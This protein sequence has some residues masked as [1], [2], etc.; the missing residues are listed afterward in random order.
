MADFIT[1]VA[2]TRPAI[3]ETLRDSF[4]VVNLTGCTVTFSAQ[5]NGLVFVDAA[6]ATVTDATNGVVTFTPTTSS[7]TEPGTYSCQWAVTFPSSGGTQK[8]PSGRWFTVEV[9]G[10]QASYTTP[11]RPGV[12]STAARPDASTA[13]VG[14]AYYDTTLGIPIWSNGTVWKN[15]AG[16][17]V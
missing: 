9:M 7:F 11:T 14:A 10:E 8:F 1:T 15:A 17:T 4:G 5:K 12:G 3:V 16:T 2:A 13:G 6:T